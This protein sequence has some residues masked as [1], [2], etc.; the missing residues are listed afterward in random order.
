MDTSYK[1][2]NI[3]IK[4]EPR[5]KFWLV[6]IFGKTIHKEAGYV[7]KIW[8]GEDWVEEKVKVK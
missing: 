8:R 4:T 3:P 2:F 5:W 1:L 7:F 6:K